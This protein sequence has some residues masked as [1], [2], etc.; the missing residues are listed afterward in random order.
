MG[1]ITKGQNDTSGV[2]YL[3]C[4]DSSIGVYMSKH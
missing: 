2:H 3:D 4:G 1:E